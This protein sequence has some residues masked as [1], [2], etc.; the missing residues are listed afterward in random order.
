MIYS[1][2]FVMDLVV[3]EQQLCD[4]FCVGFNILK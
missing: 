3:Q 1:F 4:M 2:F